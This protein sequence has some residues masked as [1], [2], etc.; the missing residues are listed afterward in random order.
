MYRCL[1]CDKRFNRPREE[2]R[3][4]PSSE[5]QYFVDI[6]ILDPKECIITVLICPYCGSDAIVMCGEENGCICVG[7]RNR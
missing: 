3:Y 5:E 4:E 7:E 6:G 1:N 2:K